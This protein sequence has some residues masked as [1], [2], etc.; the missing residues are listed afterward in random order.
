MQ[1]SRSKARNPSA[2]GAAADSSGARGS[3][4]G[5]GDEGECGEG[6]DEGREGSESGGG[7]SR[8]LQRP[9]AAAPRRAMVHQDG[10]SPTARL[11]HGHTASG[12]SSGESPEGSPGARGSGGGGRAGSSRAGGSSR[13]PGSAGGGSASAGGLAAS[14]L[15]G[16]I[17]RAAGGGGL[18]REEPLRCCLASLSLPWESLAFDLLFKEMPV[19]VDIGGRIFPPPRNPP[20]AED[21]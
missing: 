19:K 12:G 13:S 8:L 16:G 21:F 2:A 18:V 9:V 4:N 1:A 15:Q 20:S 6:K 7:S 10:D 11:P 3:G 14:L 17:G 5:G